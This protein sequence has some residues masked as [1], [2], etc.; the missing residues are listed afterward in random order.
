MP[1]SG[2][3]HSKSLLSALAQLLLLGPWGAALL[4]T[5]YEK[6]SLWVCFIS[7]RALELACLVLN[8]N[9]TSYETLCLSFSI[10]KIE[11][12]S[13]NTDP[14]TFG[15]Y[16]FQDKA[17]MIVTISLPALPVADNFISQL[18]PSLQPAQHQAQN[19][20]WWLPSQDCPFLAL[21]CPLLVTLSITPGAQRDPFLQV[22]GLDVSIHTGGT[23]KTDQAT[24]SAE[25]PTH[26]ETTGMC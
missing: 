2:P 23:C 13:T 20:L 26:T 7:S 5:F 21:P 6:V 8:P 15:T 3:L 1:T 14:G 18:P 24:H 11:W 16:I 12:L 17:D 19:E 10:S 9:S 4:A 22:L 25:F